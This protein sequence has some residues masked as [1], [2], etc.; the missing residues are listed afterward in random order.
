MVHLSA[1][2]IRLNDGWK[3]NGLRV[4]EIRKALVS[5]GVP[6]TEHAQS[7]ADK[8]FKLKHA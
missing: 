7:K 8:L 4:Q 6:E 1:L 3:V 2:P 5:F